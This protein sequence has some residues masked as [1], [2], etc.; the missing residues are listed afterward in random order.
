MRRRIWVLVVMGIFIITVL[1]AYTGWRVS[2]ANEK[3]K[4]M[5]IEKIQPFVTQESGIRSLEIN[6]NS[7]RMQG[8][9]LVPKNRV[10]ALEIENIE[11]GYRLWNV[12]RYGFAPQR[13]V[14]EMMLI[15]PVLIIREDA[16]S[17]ISPAESNWEAFQELVGEFSTLKSLTVLDA[18]VRIVDSLHCL[19]LGHDLDGWMQTSPIDSARLQLSGRLLE[20]KN[21][22][23]NVEAKINLKTVLPHSFQWTIK[24]SQ[25]PKSLPILIPEFIKVMGG[26]LSGSGKYV[27]GHYHSGFIEIKNGAFCFQNHP[28]CFKDVHVKGQIFENGL[29]LSGE[30]GDFN[31]SSMSL[32][33]SLSHLLKPQLN[34]NIASDI[35]RFSPFF[36]LLAPRSSLIVQGTG[37]F[38]LKIFGALNNPV[39]R[40][41]FDARHC[42]ISHFHMDALS[43]SMVLQDSVLNVMADGLQNKGVQLALT[44]RIDFSKP[45]FPSQT[46]VNLQGNFLPVLPSH[47][48]TYFDHWQG[49]TKATFTGPLSSPS[50]Q[51]NGLIQAKSKTGNIMQFVPDL[52]YQNHQLR[53]KLQSNGAFLLSG[54]INHFLSV[55]QDWHFQVQGAE[56][57]LQKVIGD[58]YSQ[59]I[60]GQ[61]ILLECHGNSKK[62]LCTTQGISETTDSL[63]WKWALETKHLNE[64]RHELDLTGAFYPDS[65][66]PVPFQ[67]TS[68]WDSESIQITSFSCDR[69]LTISGSIPFSKDSPFQISARLDGLTL[70]LFHPIFHRSKFYKGTIEGGIH[71]KGTR[72]APHTELAFN[73]Y[74]GRLHGFG[75]F[76]GEVAG[77]WDQDTLRTFSCKMKRDGQPIISGSVSS[78]SNDSLH[79]IIHGENLNFSHLLPAFFG[80]DRWGGRGYLKMQIAGKSRRPVLE[81]DLSVY[82]GNMGL[83]R[84]DSL[85]VQFSDTLRSGWGT[86]RHVL[87]LSQGKIYRS[88]GVKLTF[89]GKVPLFSQEDMDLNIHADGNLLNAL[90]EMSPFI[91]S[92]K[93]EGEVVFRVGGRPESPILGSGE[94]FIKNGNIQCADIVREV[95]KLQL[96]A[97]LQAED[98][99]LEIPNF[100]GTVRG[101]KFRLWNVNHSHTLPPLRSEDLGIHFGLICLE[102]DKRGIQLHLPGLMER[103]DAGM[104]AFEG[105]DSDEP[106]MISGGT[107]M[108]PRFHGMLNLNNLRLTYPFYQISQSTELNSIETFLRR[109]S[110]DIRV[111]P[112]SDVHYV[113][114]I[115]SPLGN[116][117]ADLQLKKAYGRLN[118]QGMIEDGTLQVW[119]NLESTEGNIEV[120]DMYFRPERI[121]FDYPK[122]TSNPIV[123]G[124][125]YTTVIDS[126]GIPS[127]VWLTLT[128]VDH[129]TG[130]E[131]EGG[132][133]N[134]ILFRFS[135]DNPNLARNEADL[136]EA[137]G[138]S[139]SHI[140]ER[141]YDALGLQVDNLVLRPILRPLEREMRRYL[142]LDVVRFSSKFS[143][144]LI[145]LQAVEQPVF[146][147]KFLLRSSRLTLGKYLAPGVFVTYSGQLQ[148]AWKYQYHEEG[149]GFRH[150][151]SLEYTFRPDLFV[152]ME[153]TY[154]SKLLY[155]RREDKRIWIRH[156]FPF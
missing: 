14:H 35:F 41:A 69:F 94:I 84:Y 127:T 16:D 68:L 105:F 112:L 1:G 53:V 130:L 63:T 67:G 51:L 116:V 52:V 143:S 147:P 50:G 93:G 153:Y 15:H 150:A 85:K 139:T 23:L 29:H 126:M 82:E 17:D 43:V 32:S 136:L 135:T 145:Q 71:I 102:T 58:A 62:W 119:G 142:G 99:F 77:I 26:E 97:R 11:I 89:E 88:D 80:E 134:N 79:G 122:G 56:V 121:T 96:S 55:H 64:N 70:N 81:G 5:I 118:V 106:F 103:G 114:S 101:R 25:T 33:G 36:Q 146:D 22:N 152:E 128:T 2:R 75:D 100:S 19:V 151:L 65:A 90:A 12:I 129:A 108:G 120:L 140:T 47:L 45:E 38:H 44:S 155:D 113:R 66:N 37:Q 87:C 27:S 60:E 144:N 72:K 30:I 8:V 123:T 138:Y 149:L 7:V 61:Y 13:I 154:D 156:V 141:A 42:G 91:K 54:D 18:E 21:R 73:F 98:R 115:E 125:A 57:F 31:G 104:V 137:M 46:S 148:T 78:V 83:F 86:G 131:K 133:W 76:A 92:G 49:K 132:G 10:L 110:W 34:I 3:L 24:P 74:D 109:I 20:S 117:Y 4:A 6:L 48:Q 107:D 9:H 40:G 28:F 39:V 59:W 111:R 124:R 95:K